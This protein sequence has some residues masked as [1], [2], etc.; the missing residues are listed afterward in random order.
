MTPMPR[1]PSWGRRWR[2]E[3]ARARLALACQRGPLPR[4]FCSPQATKTAGSRR[5]PGT[6]PRMEGGANSSPSRRG[7][8][9]GLA[10]LR[11]PVA[12]ARRAARRSFS[13]RVVRTTQQARP[14]AGRRRPIR[15]RLV[16]R[17]VERHLL[18]LDC[19]PGEAA[20]RGGARGV[21]VAPAF[22]HGR[23][24]ARTQG[25][26]AAATRK[27]AAGGL[28]RPIKSVGAL[29]FVQCRPPPSSRGT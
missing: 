8:W 26:S 17:S 4:G 10:P 16:W 25:V 27:G 3:G 23:Q 20:P 9:A 5:M 29:T 21:P 13:R 18:P 22:P 15:P 12:G 24:S 19:A 1:A 28:P 11:R 14:A 2:A 7:A 6:R